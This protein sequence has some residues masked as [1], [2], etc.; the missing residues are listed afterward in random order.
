MGRS[1]KLRSKVAKAYN[2]D[3]GIGYV[4]AK[5]LILEVEVVSSK[6]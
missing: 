4:R 2:K 6:L 5:S 1:G 3:S